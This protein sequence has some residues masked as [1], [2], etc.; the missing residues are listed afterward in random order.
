MPSLHGLQGVI[1][2]NADQCAY[3]LTTEVEGEERLAK[4][5]IGFLTNSWCVARELDRK[6][7][8]Y[9]AHFSLMESRSSQ[10]AAYPPGL[11]QAV[12]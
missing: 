2:V 11:Y 9:H 10:A 6:C 1:K 5:P 7:D 3:G 8:N 12:C 4:K